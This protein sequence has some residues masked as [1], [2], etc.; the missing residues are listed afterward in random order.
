MK[1]V[2]LS[3]TILM[4]LAPGA[5][6]QIKL[7][8]VSPKATV[9]QNIGL[10]EVTIQYNRPGVKGRVIWGELVPYEKVWRT[11]ANEATTINF[12]QDVKING[13][14]LPAGLYSLHTV[15]TKSAWT[16]IFNKKA[17]QWGSYE[18]D[19][20]QDALR[21]QV[22]PK[23][24]SHQE[25]M[26]FSFPDVQTET[27]TVELAWEKLRIPFQIETNTREQALANIHQALSGEVKEWTVPYSAASYAFTANLD[28]KAE[29]MKWID[30]SVSMKETYWNL[31]L[32]AT[33]LER[34]G[35]K[36]EAVAVAEKAVKLGKE[37]K[38][39]ATEI[40]K[41]EKQIA[42]WKTELGG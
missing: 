2:L 5:Y 17:E 4:L 10:T 20:A 23:Q 34:E 28:N 42:E 31:R 9:M 3:A 38:D 22:E 37:N 18:Y 29:A 25:W 24:G 41:T 13:K 11:G 21:I 40:A 12:S 15:P 36:K 39:E 8:R 26:A 30:Q 35:K 33:M 16:V 27:A 19:A 14:P 6:A 32:K 7:P 1:K